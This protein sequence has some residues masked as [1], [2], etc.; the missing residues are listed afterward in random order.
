VYCKSEYEHETLHIPEGTKTTHLKG[1]LLHYSYKDAKDHRARADKYS[2][3]TAQ[4]FSAEGKTSS[5]LKPL[6]SGIVRFIKMYFI[7]LGFL[8]GKAGLQIAWISALS[9]GYKYKELSR[10]NAQKKLGSTLKHILISRTDSLGDVML[11]LPMAGLLKEIYPNA[12]ISFLGKNYTKALITACAH[13]DE[14]ISYDELMEKSNAEQIAFIESLNLNAAI[15]VLPRKPL[16]EL[17]KSAKVPLRIGT[18][19]RL[20]N[21]LRCNRFVHFTRKG[22]ELHES[23]LNVRMLEALHCNA[24]KSLTELSGYYGFTP[25]VTQKK[26]VLSSKPSIILHPKSQGSAPEWKL[27]NFKDL[28][29]L[30]TKACLLYTSPSPRDRTRSRMPSSA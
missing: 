7:K 23:Q 16:A 24:K 20:Y 8:D 9:N 30:L 3:L 21:L 28:A 11:T 15:H 19:R 2:E 13:V 17:F 22:S 29:Q 25:Q 1:D 5:A 10:I 4:K 26:V 27:K 6:T 12:K 14:Y 18:S